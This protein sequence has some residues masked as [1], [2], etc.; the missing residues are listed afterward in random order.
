MARR[1]APTTRRIITAR[2]LQHSPP[3]VMRRRAMRIPITKAY[4]LVV[5]V[6]WRPHC[7]L[8]CRW[9]AACSVHGSYN[10]LSVSIVYAPRCVRLTFGKCAFIILGRETYSVLSRPLRGGGVLFVEFMA[11]VPVNLFCVTELCDLRVLGLQQLPTYWRV[12]PNLLCIC[13]L[14]GLWLMAW[15]LPYYRLLSFGGAFGCGILGLLVP[16]AL[17]YVH[18]LRNGR[19]AVMPGQPIAAGAA[20]RRAASLVRGYIVS[21]LTMICQLFVVSGV[22]LAV[23]GLWLVMWVV[24]RTSVEG[25]LWLM[26]SCRLYSSAA[27]P[28]PL[29]TRVCPPQLL[30]RLT[31]FPR[32]FCL[33]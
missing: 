29:Y 30:A 21:F 27:R 23:H 16:G 14:A 33:E 5:Y 18:H 12:G 26:S 20:S 8:P 6:I 1:P 10:S 22:T 9:R 7:V 32:P 25:D 3:Y 11:I 19:E 31:P 13:L 17:D 4:C 24:G 2:L 28:L 15:A